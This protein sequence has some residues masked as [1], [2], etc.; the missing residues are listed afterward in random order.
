MK[1]IT[2][3]PG[4]AK[5]PKN[6]SVRKWLE[7]DDDQALAFDDYG[8]MRSA[9]WSITSYLRSANHDYKATSRSIDEGFIIAKVKK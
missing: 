9:L 8:E 6:R 2:Y 4:K 7:L 1:I 5:E 3:A